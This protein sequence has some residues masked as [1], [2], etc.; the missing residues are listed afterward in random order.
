MKILVPLEGTELEQEVLR[1]ARLLA[2]RNRAE[3]VLLRVVPDPIPLPL[4]ASPQEQARVDAQNQALRVLAKGALERTADRLR[5]ARLRVTTQVYEGDPVEGILR[6]VSTI[7]ADLIVMSA[8][9]MKGQ[10]RWLD[11][12]MTRRV[13]NESPVPVVAVGGTPYPGIPDTFVQPPAPN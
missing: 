11:S 8:A 2:V 5:A 4:L 13:V 10:D 3:L 7:C 9:G 1:Q 12:G 6:C